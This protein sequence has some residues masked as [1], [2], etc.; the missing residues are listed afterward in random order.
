MLGQQHERGSARI[1]G[2]AHGEHVLGDVLHYVGQ[3][4]GPGGDTHYTFHNELN[5]EDRQFNDKRK[6]IRNNNF[7]IIIIALYNSCVR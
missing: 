6:F 4:V 5:N 1:T 2:L 3:A 7:I